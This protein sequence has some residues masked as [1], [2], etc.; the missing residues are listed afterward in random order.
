MCIR[1]VTQC[2]HTNVVSEGHHPA[3]GI[4]NVPISHPLSARLKFPRKVFESRKSIGQR[5][6]MVAFVIKASPYVVLRYPVQNLNAP[7]A[8]PAM[9]NTGGTP[10]A[11]RVRPSK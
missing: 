9:S 2:L 5:A 4:V 3:L 7:A 6:V 10:N 8:H 1:N 11:D